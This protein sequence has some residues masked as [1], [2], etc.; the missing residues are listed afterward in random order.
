MNTIYRGLLQLI[1]ST[2]TGKAMPLPERFILEEAQNVISS[3][4]LVP[5]IYPGAINCGIF[6]KSELMQK[7]QVD[8]FRHLVTSDRQVRTVDQIC[9]AFEENGIEYMPLKGYILKKL[10]PKPEMRAM[11][12]A[13]ILIRLEQYEKIQS[14]MQSLRFHYKGESFHDY[15]WENDALYLELHKRL[16]AKNEGELYQFF[17][18][19][20][21]VAVR[22]GGYRHRLNAEEEYIYLFSHIVKHF[23]FSGIGVKHFVDLYLY[24]IAHPDMDEEKIERGMVTL[25]L[26]DFYRNAEQMIKVWFEG[27]ESDPTS[28]MMSDYVF[29]GGSFG[30]LKNRMYYEGLVHASKKKKGAKNA[31]TKSLFQEIF[32]SLHAMQLAYNILLKWP[33]LLPI[34]W[35]IRWVDVL[36]HRRK[37]IGDKFGVIRGMTDEKML[38]WESFMNQ[39]GIYIEY[40]ED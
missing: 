5:L 29:S 20:W 23:R 36:L 18:D 40:A 13:D 27:Q 16:F 12:D 32:P 8:Y 2:L 35:P 22:D 9:K 14:V 30:T 24:R 11:C 19:G 15:V 10:Y 34:Y 38:H 37:R 31:K 21:D 33:I 3:Q 39:M 28:E 17:G 6:A 7:Y 26:L 4:S 1:K 25:R